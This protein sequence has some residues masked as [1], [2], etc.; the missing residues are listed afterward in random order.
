MSDG[1]PADQ[2]QPEPEAPAGEPKPKPDLQG[3]MLATLDD[4]AAALRHL[5]STM[6]AHAGLGMIAGRIAGRTAVARSVLY[7]PEPA[8]SPE[9]E[10]GH[11]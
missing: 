4:I 3:M 7:P 11:G 2:P 10:A 6:P 5:S 8:P 9:A 1:H